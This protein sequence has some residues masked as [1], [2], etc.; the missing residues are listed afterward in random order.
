MPE[1]VKS[2]L[3]Y[4]RKNVNEGQIFELQVLYEHSWPKLTEDY[5]EKRPWP[6]ESEVAAIVD[7]DPVSLYLFH[8]VLWFVI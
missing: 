5:F 4:F 7:N 2:F 6:E 3:V 8:V 1:Q